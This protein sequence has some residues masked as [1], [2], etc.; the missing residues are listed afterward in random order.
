[1]YGSCCWMPLGQALELVLLSGRRD[2]E[3]TVGGR[4]PAMTPG[5]CERHRGISSHLLLEG[6]NSLRTP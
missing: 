5:R 6:R 2:P 1:M 3:E 4:E